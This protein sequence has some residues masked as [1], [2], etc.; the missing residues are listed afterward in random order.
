MGVFTVDDLVV[1]AKHPVLTDT[2][3][4]TKSQIDVLFFL[5]KEDA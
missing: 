3:F 4:D 1:T 2:T 5:V